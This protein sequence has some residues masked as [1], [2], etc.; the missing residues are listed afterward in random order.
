VRPAVAAQRASASRRGTGLENG[1][2]A[3]RLC[4]RGRLPSTSGNKTKAV[5]TVSWRRRGAS[6]AVHMRYSGQL[7]LTAPPLQVVRYEGRSRPSKV[8]PF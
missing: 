8:A 1:L 2:G 5:L 7:T 3:P 4:W 6:T